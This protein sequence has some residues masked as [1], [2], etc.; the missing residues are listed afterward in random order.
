MAKVVKKNFEAPEEIRPIDKGKV[1]VVDLGAMKVMRTT[2]EPGWR[3][4]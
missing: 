4:S 1:E 2:F 3:W